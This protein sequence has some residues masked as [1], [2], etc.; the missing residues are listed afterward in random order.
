MRA[1][2]QQHSEA[3]N[4][5]VASMRITVEDWREGKGYDLNALDHVS[6]AERQDLVNVL[7]EELRDNPDWRQAEALAA[8]GTPAAVRVLRTAMQ[9]ANPELRIHIAG[10]LAALG[11]PA[12]L[13][14]AI[15]E[16]LR[17]TTLSSGF[18]YAIDTAAEHPTPRIRETLL[19]VSLNGDA[20][21][22]IHC[23]ALALYLGGQA[24]EPFDWNHRP[25]FLRFG[26]EDPKV[27][28]DA[29]KEL[30]ERL[31]VAAKVK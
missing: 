5:F 13:E 8:I 11:E 7:A 29:Y 31:G 19:D 17:N 28:M 1:P 15:I 6:E 12:D 10:E 30:C 14:S 24:D 20:E 2:T 9:T 16:A 22:R 21:R 26:D 3:Y 18:S 23:A 25:F 4:S 27:R